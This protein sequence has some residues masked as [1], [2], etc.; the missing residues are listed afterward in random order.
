MHWLLLYNLA[1]DYLERRPE[2]RAEHLRLAQ[3]AHAR[4][5]LL[6]AGALSNP[7]D[8]AI[9][10]FTNEPVARTFAETDPY[11][12]HGLV[13]TWRVRRWNTVVGEGSSPP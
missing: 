8:A 9:L 4:G 6:L 11:V 13:A 1:P 7:F 12:L 3:E 5:D 2:F 10:L